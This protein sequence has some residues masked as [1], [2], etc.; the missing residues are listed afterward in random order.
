MDV[1]SFQK[2][3]NYNSSLFNNSFFLFIDTYKHEIFR[4]SFQVCLEFVD[5]FVYV[6]ISHSPL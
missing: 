5:I 2:R 1:V 6:S 4:A 3:Y